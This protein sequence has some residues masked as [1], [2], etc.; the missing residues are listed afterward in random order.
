MLKKFGQSLKLNIIVNQNHI[1]EEI[2]HRLNS[3]NSE[4]CNFPVVLYGCEAL[5][6][7]V[8]EDN[9]LRV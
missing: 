7:T 6:L 1:D 8:R 2:K 9:R 3:A 5:S 4:N